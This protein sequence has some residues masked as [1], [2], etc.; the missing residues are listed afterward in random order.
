MKAQSA[1]SIVV[2]PIAA[3]QA[4][5]LC[6]RLHYSGKVVPNSQLHFGVFL[7]GICQGVMQFGPSMDKRKTIGLVKDTSWNGFLELN[8][9]AFS[10][11]LPRNSESRAIAVAI[12]LIKKHYP[13]V[14]WILSFADATVCGDGAIYRAS[15]FKLIGI[16]KNTALWLMR[17]GTRKSTMSLYH[18]TGLRISQKRIKSGHFPN[19]VCLSQG[20]QLRYIYFIDPEAQKKLTVNILPF[21][22]IQ[23]FGASMYKGKKRAKSIDNDA[24]GFQSEEGGANP[25]LALQ[26]Q[27]TI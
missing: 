16:N 23:K 14:K 15:G 9:M 12:K 21:D 11:V 1:K 22:T 2:K 19:A 8:R 7:N 6:K 18:E 17:D 10:E 4:N 5:Q 3:S 25:T 26:S 20:F 24:S 13:H 27:E